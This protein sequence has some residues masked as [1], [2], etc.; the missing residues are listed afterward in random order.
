MTG[1]AQKPTDALVEW[2]GGQLRTRS[3][4][5]MLPTDNELALTWH[6]SSK[7]V[8]RIMQTFV[9]TGQIIR[10][11]GKGTF[12]PEVK[13]EEQQQTYVQKRSSSGNLREQIYRSL[14]SGQYR[15]GEALPSINLPQSITLNLRAQKALL[16]RVPEIERIVARLA[17]DAERT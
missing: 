2:V 15:H 5:T 1:I 6:L 12:I 11:R 3:P 16:E 8:G 10:M 13:S 4:G 7:T 17:Q 14:C 9:A